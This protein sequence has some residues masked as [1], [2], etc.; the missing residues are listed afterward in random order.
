[1]VLGSGCFVYIDQQSLDIEYIHHL[2]PLSSCISIYL[3][4]LAQVVYFNGGGVFREF[5]FVRASSLNKARC[6]QHF[7]YYE[8]LDNFKW[9]SINYF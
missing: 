9:P 4:K 2:Y 1:M 3:Y 5:L 8:L 6:M 7:S